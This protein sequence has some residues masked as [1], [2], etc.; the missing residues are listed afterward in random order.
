MIPGD[1]YDKMVVRKSGCNPVPEYF[2]DGL[3]QIAEQFVSQPE[4]VPL[5]E[6]LKV[7]DI[8]MYD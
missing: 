3:C 6:K 4:T 8:K 7:R 5:I 1:A 2:P